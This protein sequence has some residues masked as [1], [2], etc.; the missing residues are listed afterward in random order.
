M[1]FDGGNNRNPLFR[2]LSNVAILLFYFL[3]NNFQQPRIFVSFSRGYFYLSLPFY[4]FSNIHLNIK[5]AK[6]LMEHNSLK[7]KVKK[8]MKSSPIHSSPQQE[9]KD[10][11]IKENLEPWERER[12]R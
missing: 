4:A 5:A 11:R 9:K 2:Y 8:D 10:P 3:F 6:L 7:P 1:I 12:K